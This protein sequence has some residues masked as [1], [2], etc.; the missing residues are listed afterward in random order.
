[1]EVLLDSNFII[2]C[3]KEKIDFITQLEEQGFKVSL[4]LEVYQE[5]KDLKYKVSQADR[6]A[7]KIAFE[8]FEKIGI[9]KTKLGNDAV[10]RELIKKGKQG[11]FIATLDAA[12]KKEIPNKVII[13]TSQKRIG[14]E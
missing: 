5:L 10:D 1:M 14:I 8:I 2:A 11:C 4:P 7:I 12:I 6:E 9:K 3:V 13:F